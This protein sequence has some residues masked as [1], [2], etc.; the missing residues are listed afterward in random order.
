M[1]AAVPIF[2]LGWMTAADALADACY[3]SSRSS[4]DAIREVEKELCYEFVGMSQGDIDWSCNNE[5]DEMINTQ[6]QKVASCSSDSIGTC[7]AALTQESLSNYR[8]TAEDEDQARPA[9]PND[10][11]VVTHYYNVGDLRQVR[12][13]C[14]N[15]GGT[16]RGKQ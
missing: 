8:S 5:S 15:A 3:V 6:Q 9:I 16:W 4:S 1:Q 2:L 11:K 7:E 12:L 13:D 14:E 10:A